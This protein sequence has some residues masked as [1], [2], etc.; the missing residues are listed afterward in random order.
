MFLCTENRITRTQT[1]SNLIQPRC[2]NLYTI[3]C[4]H[5]F[6]LLAFDFLIVFLT[7][8]KTFSVKCFMT[9]YQWHHIHTSNESQSTQWYH[10]N[11]ANIYCCKKTAYSPL[12]FTADCYLL[13]WQ[14]VLIRYDLMSKATT[15][16][17]CFTSWPF[18]DGTHTKYTFCTLLVSP[19]HF[20]WCGVCC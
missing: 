15:N 13:N 19:T 9:I 4:F 17:Y 20:K 18:F 5:H 1:N 10:G 12:L 14:I 8:N 6:T 16:I 7:N 3:Y 11:C 2:N